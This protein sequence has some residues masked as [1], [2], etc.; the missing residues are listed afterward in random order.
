MLN[1]HDSISCEDYFVADPAG[2]FVRNIASA[3]G[4]DLRSVHHDKA[5]LTF[6]AILNQRANLTALRIILVSVN[7]VNL[8][9]FS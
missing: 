5:G 9:Q 2:W 7:P 4:Q 6:S 1:L 8:I 3:I